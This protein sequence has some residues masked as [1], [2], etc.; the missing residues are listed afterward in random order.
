MTRSFYFVVFGTPWWFTFPVLWRSTIKQAFE[1]DSGFIHVIDI[2]WVIVRN[3]QTNIKNLVRK[4]FNIYINRFTVN[5]LVFPDNFYC[6]FLLPRQACLKLGHC[7]HL[8]LTQKGI[9]SVGS[10]QSIPAKDFPGSDYTTWNEFTK[11]IN[12]TQGTLDYV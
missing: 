8:Y 9:L 10:N 4:I 3:D 7:V 1:E 12:K 11:R 2:I 6:C 5:S